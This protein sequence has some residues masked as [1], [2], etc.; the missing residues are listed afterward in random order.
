M[1]RRLFFAATMI[2]SLALACQLIVGIERTDKAERPPEASVPDTTPP[3]IP[4]PC[5]HVVVPP[6]PDVDDDITGQLPPFAVGLRAFEVPGAGEPIGFDLD[7]RCTCDPRPGAAFDGG[8][9]CNAPLPNCDLDGG[10]DNQMGTVVGGNF[11]L[12]EAANKRINDGQQTGLLR[13]SGY[14]G[15]AN[16]KSVFVELFSSEGVRVPSPCD[17]GA[18]ASPDASTG[19]DTFRPGWCGE[20]TWTVSQATVEGEGTG[21]RAK[22][23]GTGYVTNWQLVVKVDGETRLPFTGYDL[24]VGS[25]L[26]VGTLVAVD[27]NL[28]PRDAAAPTNDPEIQRLWRVQNG[29]FAGRVPSNDLL[30]VIGII[31]SP[32]QLPKP[33]GEKTYVC[34]VPAIF[35][36]AVSNVCNARDVASSFR[37]DGDPN[38]RCDAVSLALRASYVPVRLGA[39]AQTPIMT[40]QCYP[41]GSSGTI[42]NVPN[43][44][45]DCP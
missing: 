45:Y 42:G 29:T 31:Q 44:S 38:A 21:F 17:A 7:G 16:D 34:E 26:T 9:S 18:D 40:N 22:A 43:V 24:R 13:I 5:A 28:E 41:N 6:P 15:R 10:I 4:D 27:K 20:D 14:N 19:V 32:F 8:P 2:G 36:I 37:L 39:I 23:N 12:A 25:P 35:T 33:N 1:K 11:Q 3:V 30:A